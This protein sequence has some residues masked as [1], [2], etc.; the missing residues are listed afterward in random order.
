MESQYTISPHARLALR[1]DQA[2]LGAPQG[3]GLLAILEAL[4]SPA[5]AQAACLVPLGKPAPLSRLAQDSGRDAGELGE[6]L[7]GLAGRGLCYQRQTPQGAY[8]SLLPVVPGMAETQFMS[9]QVNEDKRHLAR[10]FAAYYAPGLG[11]SLVEAAAPYSR[12]IPVGRA[13]QSN[14]EILP[15]EQ[16]EQVV[17]GAGAM[18]LGHCYCRHEAELNGQGCG[19]PKD[20]CLIFGPFARFAVDKGIAQPADLKTAMAALERA[21]MAS[22]VHVTDNVRQGA[23]FLCNCCGCCCMF[24]KTITQL[25]SP[26]AV[27]QAGYL[28]VVDQDNC[29]ACGQCRDICQVAAPQPNEEAFAV[30]PALCL[31]CGHCSLACPTGAIGM[32]RRPRPEPPAAYADLLAALAQ[33]RAEKKRLETRP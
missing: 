14:Q 11:R 3:P 23:N 9:G 31:G 16:A 4:F 20:V 7:D 12:V 5:E 30:D 8:Y 10:L 32:E 21:E 26:G 13:V 19:A 18:A 33:G 17:R 29:T 1:L 6:I 2:P 15:F 22:L 27:A 24:L 25:K 28:A